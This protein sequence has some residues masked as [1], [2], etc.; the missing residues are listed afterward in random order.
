MKLIYSRRKVT[1]E[2]FYS[3]ELKLHLIRL[4]DPPH[5]NI[6]LDEISIINKVEYD[7]VTNRFVEFCL[8]IENGIPVADAFVLYTFDEIKNAIDN[9]TVGKYAHCVVAKSVYTSV[10]TFVSFA[11]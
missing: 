6:R 4:K 3:D 5:V 9:E 1:K 10:P 7:P 2:E 11:M 8:P